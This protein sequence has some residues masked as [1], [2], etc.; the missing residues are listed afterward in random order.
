MLEQPDSLEWGVFDKAK[1]TG[2][3]D[4]HDGVQSFT[5]TQ[6]LEFAQQLPEVK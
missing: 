1:F 2:Y 5:F 6:C 4:Y 3:T